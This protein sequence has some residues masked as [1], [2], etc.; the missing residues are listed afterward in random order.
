MAAP[1]P[2][3]IKHWRMLFIAYA[4]ALTIATH[5]P[6]LQVDTGLPGNDKT[7]HFL[8]FG[9][10]TIL[11]WQTRWV[12]RL[13]LCGLIVLVWSILDE[14]SQELP[15]IHRTMTYTDLIANAL[16]VLAATT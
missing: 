13:W 2:S 7:I 4:L 5:W 6:R 8:A 12:K 15:G 14:A 3:V 9:G 11:L 1:N 10:L 16:G